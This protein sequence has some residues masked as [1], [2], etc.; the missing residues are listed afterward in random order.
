MKTYNLE[1]IIRAKQALK[2]AATLHIMDTNVSLID[3]GFR[4]HDQDQ[5]CIEPE[6]TVR[7]HVHRKLRGAD[8]A[9]L[10]EKE[11]Q[12]VISA[13]RI[14][15]AVD[16]IEASYNAQAV[17]NDHADFTSTTVYNNLTKAIGTVGGSVCDRFT[18]EEM[19]LGSWSTLCG[20]WTK[21]SDLSIRQNGINT[22]A[23]CTRHSVHQ[24]LDAAVAKL[25]TDQAQIKNPLGAGA[26]TGAIFPRLGMKVIK[27][28]S[29]SGAASGIIDGICGCAL[30]NLDGIRCI[31]KNIVRIVPDNSSER[32]CTKGDSGAWW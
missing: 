21:Q 5:N 10:A 6:L 14:G 29:I 23:H 26:V 22:P 32:F 27:S 24:F 20:S 9:S 16:V 3:I 28:G 13:E 30:I 2:K 8:F 7:V 17:S 31:V 1:S 25:T 4:I 15:F 18:K 11:S 19:I 12:R